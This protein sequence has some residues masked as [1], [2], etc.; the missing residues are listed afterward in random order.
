MTIVND[1]LYV[2]N[3]VGSIQYL[4]LTGSAN[5]GY[6]AVATTFTIQ[7]IGTGHGLSGTVR[8]M[9]S[10]RTFIYQSSNS[11]SGTQAI[12]HGWDYTAGSGDFVGRANDISSVTVD[13]D[14]A[15]D[16]DGT[17]Y[18]FDILRGSSKANKLYAFY[19]TGAQTARI[20]NIDRTH[21]F[22]LGSRQASTYGFRSVSYTHLTLPTNREV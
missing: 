5:A 2:P 7:S 13:A 22:P 1:R 10:Y 4:A 18:V 19:P 3:D 15:V 17:F 9:A 6:T 8:G 20:M 11:A 14:I 12:A 16:T 21:S